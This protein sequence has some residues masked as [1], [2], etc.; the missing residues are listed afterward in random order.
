ML[1]RKKLSDFWNDL[2]LDNQ[3]KN[4]QW[5]LCSNDDIV[6]VVNRRKDRR[7]EVKSEDKSALK[8]R[9]IFDNR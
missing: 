4:A 5:L 1:G 8:I 2:K 9:L 3:A 7:F 6:W